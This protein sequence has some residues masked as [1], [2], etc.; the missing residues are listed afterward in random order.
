MQSICPV[1]NEHFGLGRHAPIRYPSLAAQSRRRGW[2]LDYPT[3]RQPILTEMAQ[4]QASGETQARRAHPDGG[5]STAHHHARPV[6]D[7]ARSRSSV[8][9]YSLYAYLLPLLD[10]TR[11]VRDLPLASGSARLHRTPDGGRRRAHLGPDARAPASRAAPPRTR[12]RAG[13]RPQAASGSLDDA[14][15]LLHSFSACSRPIEQ[16]AAALDRYAT[17]AR[18]R[19]PGARSPPTPGSRSSPSRTR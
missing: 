4:A 5:R 2:F 17:A 11:Q 18:Q 16:Q 9:A 19:L 6:A 13:P 10:H 1:G 12:A 7:L 3:V 15:G 8:V 14:D